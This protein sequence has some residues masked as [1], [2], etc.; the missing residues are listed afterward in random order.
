MHLRPIDESDDEL[1]ASLQEQEDVWQFIGGLPLL[2]DDA[3]RLFAVIE[4]EASVGIAGLVQSE[5]LDG[6]DFE[7]ICAMRE[8]AQ[9]HGF[10]KQAC[11]LVLEWAFNTAKVERI[12]ASIDDANE[13]AQS[14]ATK[15]GMKKS[16]VRSPS[17]TVYVKYRDE[18]SSGVNQYPIK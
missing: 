1:L 12:I 6:R 3:H 14:I 5:A 9:L 13:A 17:R 2:P 7:L 4:G 11:A 16:V 8:E 10:A 18:R 15:L